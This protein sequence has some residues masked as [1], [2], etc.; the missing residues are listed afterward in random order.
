MCVTHFAT[1][2]V[3][4]PLLWKP[5]SL[6]HT[7]YRAEPGGDVKDAFYD[8]VQP[9]CTVLC[10]AI[11]TVHYKSYRAEQGR[12][13]KDVFCDPI[14]AAKTVM[15]VEH[16]TPAHLHQ[17]LPLIIMMMMMMTVMMFMMT[18]MMWMLLMV[19]MM[20]AER[21]T[22]IIL[23]LTRLQTNPA[24]ASKTQSGELGHSLADCLSSCPQLW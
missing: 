8:L 1:S 17:T 12:G 3:S 19:I 14:F 20:R 21:Y 11:T 4:K 23:A 5:L 16:Y 13:V 15:R 22:C 6:H 7:N 18:M 10:A 2:C 24:P 9:L